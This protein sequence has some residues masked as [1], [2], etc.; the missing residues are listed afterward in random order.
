MRALEV[1][2]GVGEGVELVVPGLDRLD[3]HRHELREANR[4]EFLEAR[5]E[6]VEAHRDHLVGVDAASLRDP[7]WR[8]RS[9]IPVRA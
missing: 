8:T 3:G 4:D 5:A 9:G 6:R 1:E 7:Q 2:D